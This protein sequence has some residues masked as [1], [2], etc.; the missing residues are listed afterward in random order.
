MP[1]SPMRKVTWQTRRAGAGVALV[2]APLPPPTERLQCRAVSIAKACLLG[3]GEDLASYT[4]LLAQPVIRVRSVGLSS[5][6][7]P[8]LRGALSPSTR[9]SLFYWFGRDELYVELGRSHYAP[10]T[11]RSGPFPIRQLRSH[12]RADDTTLQATRS[13]TWPY[14]RE[15][16]CATSGTTSLVH[17]GW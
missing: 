16:P 12:C 8:I 14:Q 5:C 3:G 10:S 1:L 17:R 6:G 15:I 4:Y 2:S 13:N 11:H 9:F 7:C